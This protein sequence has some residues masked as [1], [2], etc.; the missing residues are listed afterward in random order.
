MKGHHWFRQ[1]HDATSS[2]M[3]YGITR[4]QQYVMQQ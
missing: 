4:G 1:W 2:M 3:Q